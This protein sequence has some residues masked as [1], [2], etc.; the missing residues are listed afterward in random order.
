MSP[1]SSP[2]LVE[3]CR[4]I[5]LL[6]L[7]VDGVLTAG[8]VEFTDDGTESKSFHV[9][10]GTGLKLWQ[11][12]GRRTAWISGRSS[13]SVARRAAELGVEPVIEGAGDKL[14]AYRQVLVATGM[15]PDEVCCVGDDLADLPVF[16]HCGLAVAVADACVEIRTAAHFI[17]Q[18]AGGRGAVA[19]AGGGELIQTR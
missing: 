6:V 9:R 10:D 8:G 5:R 3:R 7:D 12:A 16:G 17:T 15:R 19:A 18:A 2:S 1:E 13:P 11:Q 4:A 14:A